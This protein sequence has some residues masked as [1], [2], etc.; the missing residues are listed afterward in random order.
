MNRL[1]ELFSGKFSDYKLQNSTSNKECNV[2]K[3]ILALC[4]NFFSENFK[5]NSS[6]S[7][8]LLLD[9]DYT[10]EIIL[11][12][13]RLFYFENEEIKISFEKIKI[14]M[15]LAK[16]LKVIPEIQGKIINEYNKSIDMFLSK[17]LITIKSVYK[18]YKDLFISKNS[19]L[20]TI[21]DEISNNENVQQLK[22]KLQNVM[23]SAD[24]TLIES[25]W[26]VDFKNEFMSNIN[27]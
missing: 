9:T 10:D 18:I 24:I 16:E 12:M 21:G 11:C 26:G 15:K 2:H 27:K 5:S 8:Y 13:M 23:K 4:S 22:L 14:L 25:R 19:L 20:S 7:T 1:E 3:C 17:N 6:S